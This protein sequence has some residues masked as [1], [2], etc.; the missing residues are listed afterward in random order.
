[1]YKNKI[2]DKALE[3]IKIKKQDAEE[4]ERERTHRF[5]ESFFGPDYKESFKEISHKEYDRLF[6]MP[7]GYEDIV[8]CIDV[9]S[10]EGSYSIYRVID[11]SYRPFKSIPHY[12]DCGFTD[13]YC[14][15]EDIKEA[16][17]IAK[18]E[19]ENEY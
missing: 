10:N 19:N 1:M 4:R 8:F 14:F 5:M 17:D 2:I 13:I 11:H 6:F 18:R 9:V 15:A 12:S 3:D 16:S 7:I